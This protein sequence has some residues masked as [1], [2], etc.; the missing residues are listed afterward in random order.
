MR[1]WA[2]IDMHVMAPLPDAQ[3]RP[4]GTQHR[5]TISFTLCL[6][7]HSFTLSLSLSPSFVSSLP[8]HFLSL[9]LPLL[10]NSD[11][12]RDHGRPLI[13]F[14][15][16]YCTDS[17]SPKCQQSHTVSH[18]ACRTQEGHLVTI[19]HRMAGF[20]HYTVGLSW[21]VKSTL[22]ETGKQAAASQ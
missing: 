6:L 11:L 16:F 7:L 10:L 14:V 1:E 22:T 8:P 19:S 21:A 15:S 5:Y 17:K 18:W 20:I 9:S 12:D 3:F 13:S 4:C 2:V